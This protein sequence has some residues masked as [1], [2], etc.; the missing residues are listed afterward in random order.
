[1]NAAV[2]ENLIGI[3]NELIW[4]TYK[5]GRYREFY[6]YEPKKRLIMA[7]SFKDRVVQWAIYLQINN[8]FD[9]QFITHS[10]GCRVG[11]G[12]TRAADRLQYWMEYVDRKPDPWYYLKLDISKYFY[13]EAR[14]SLNTEKK[15][16]REASLVMETI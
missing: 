10:Y 6:V 16:R 14:C 12:T 15:D 7:L 5:V 9:R 8:L 2:Q 4:R 13:G 1:M 3:Q 11:K